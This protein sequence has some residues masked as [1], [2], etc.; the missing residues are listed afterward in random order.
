MVHHFF[1]IN[2]A[3]DDAHPVV[4]YREYPMCTFVTMHGRHEV[5]FLLG[6][7]VSELL[8][9]MHQKDRCRAQ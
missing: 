8:L 6:Y 5:P 2:E 7:S 1:F 3:E 4:G 9:L